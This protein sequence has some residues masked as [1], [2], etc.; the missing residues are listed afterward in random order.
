MTG[1]LARNS[2]CPLCGGRL[3]PGVA[4]IPFV[5]PDTVVLIKD[6]PAEICHS[7]HEPYMVGKMTDK[8]TN[9]LNQLRAFRAEVSIVSYSE[10]QPVPTTTTGVRAFATVGES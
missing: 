9:L 10:L 2:R 6:V 3:R 7:C 1:E 5:L 8:I 4:T